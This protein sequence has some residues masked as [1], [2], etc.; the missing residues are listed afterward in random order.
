[1]LSVGNNPSMLSVVKLGVVML[2]VVLLIVV[3]PSEYTHNA[4]TKSALLH[5]KNFSFFFIFAIEA[6]IWIWVFL[7][8]HSFFTV[9]IT[10]VIFYK[11]ECF[12]LSVT[13][14]LGPII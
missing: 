8:L 11:L 14:T 6:R 5:E 3:A 1:M 4:I 10:T 9:V 12:S 7:S 13:S 2:S